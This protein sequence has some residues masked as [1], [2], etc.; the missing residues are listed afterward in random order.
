MQILQ[1]NMT[2]QQI[3]SVTFFV[4]FINFVFVEV[5]QYLMEL[6]HGGKRLLTI[7]ELRAETKV[8]QLQSI[9]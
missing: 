6:L 5:F 4:L 8:C 7:D 3:L 2:R 9:L 1:I